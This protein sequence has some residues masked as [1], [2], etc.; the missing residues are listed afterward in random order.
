MQAQVNERSEYLKEQNFQISL[1][2]SLSHY[3]SAGQGIKAHGKEE[4]DEMV[5]IRNDAE[6]ERQFKPINHHAI[7]SESTR[8]T[9]IAVNHSRSS[10]NSSSFKR[11]NFSS[12]SYHEQQHATSSS[13][14]TAAESINANKQQQQQQQYYMNS[15]VVN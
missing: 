14:A 5:N 10:N 12:S 3:L 2:L 15:Q 8:S 1:S 4:E 6:S 7:V 11:N 13:A 9:P